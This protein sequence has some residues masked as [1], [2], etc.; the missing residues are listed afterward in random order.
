[1][2]L[3]NPKV[4]EQIIQILDAR[5][6]KALTKHKPRFFVVGKVTQTSPLQCQIE[7]STISVPVQ[8]PNGIS[9][10]VNDKVGIIFPNCI[11]NANRFII[12]KY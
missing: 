4:A 12:F 6:Q 2:D 7:E 11:D 5:I 10:S 1:M 9:L 3:N 8:N